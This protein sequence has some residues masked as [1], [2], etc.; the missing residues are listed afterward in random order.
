MIAEEF[1][2]WPLTCIYCGSE[3]VIPSS[4]KLDDYLCC[5]CGRYQLSDEEEE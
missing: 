1:V 2:V 3:Q 4:I 5:D